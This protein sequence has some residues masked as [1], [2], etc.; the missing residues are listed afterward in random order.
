M[1][2]IV[3]VSVVVNPCL[4]PP[5]I[6]NDG[7]VYIGVLELVELVE[8]ASGGVTV[9]TGPV[10]VVETVE[11]MKVPVV[12]GLVVLGTMVVSVTGTMVLDV[13][14]SEIVL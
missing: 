8:L 7:S 11:L 4:E 14:F 1:P 5:L 6:V 10:K 12:E 2:L 13:P 9:L 3:V